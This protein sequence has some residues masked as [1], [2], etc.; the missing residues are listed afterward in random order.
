MRLEPFDCPQCGEVAK[1]TLETLSGVA[2]LFKAIDNN[3]NPTGEV[4][5]DGY[6]EIF[7]NDQQTVHRNGNPVLIC[8]SGHTWEATT[9]EDF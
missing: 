6:T 9:H 4:E 3:G 7:W 2:L 8:S 5:Y 1:G